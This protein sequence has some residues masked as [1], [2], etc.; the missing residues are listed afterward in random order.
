ML[1]FTILFLARRRAVN[2]AAWI[3]LILLFTVP[4]WNFQ[5]PH[6]EESRAAAGR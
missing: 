1:T 3:A 5:Q 2:I 6:K 4:Y